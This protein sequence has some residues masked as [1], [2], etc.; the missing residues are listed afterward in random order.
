MMLY[1]VRNLCKTYKEGQVLANDN[2]SFDLE[3]G[4]IF[5]LLGPNGAGKTTLVRMM[6][7]LLAPSSGELSLMGHDVVANP[8]KPAD[9]VSY[10]TQ[11]P[12]ALADLTV[13]EAL[14]ITGH[15]RGMG[16][17]AAR[18]QASE[19]VEEFDL[20]GFAHRVLGRLSGGQQRLTAFCLALMGDRPVMILD[21]PTNDLDPVHR[22]WLWDKLVELNRDRGTTIILVTHNVTEAERVLRRVGIIN[23]GRITA[24]DR[25]GAL[26]ARVGDSIRMELC[27][28][29]DANRDCQAQKQLLSRIFNGNVTRMDPGRWQVLAPR[30]RAQEDISA[31]LEQVGL[32]NLEDMRILLPTL[33]DVYMKLGGSEQLARAN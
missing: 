30:N 1:S 4:E 3:Q 9:L 19:L 15:L 29:A 10:V 20:G 31:A 21:E 13:R 23:K 17:P 8:D 28:R 5:G 16:R 26:K 11:R 14:A 32:D 6:M 2:L 12:N 18:R 22:R 25:V 7:G 27:F 33:E 24:M